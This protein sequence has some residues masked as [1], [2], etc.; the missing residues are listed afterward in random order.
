MYL[1]MQMKICREKN[2]LTYRNFAWRKLG[3]GEWVVSRFQ[4]Q[5]KMSHE[6]FVNDS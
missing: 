5:Y 2:V 1:Q 4:V 3:S 6:I